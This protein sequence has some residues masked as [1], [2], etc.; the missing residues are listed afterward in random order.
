MWLPFLTSSSVSTD[1]APREGSPAMMRATIRALL[2]SSGNCNPK[3]QYLVDILYWIRVPLV[4]TRRLRRKTPSPSRASV[5]LRADWQ[6][7]SRKGR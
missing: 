7:R 6:R 3:N 2:K 1:I 5:A 4:Q